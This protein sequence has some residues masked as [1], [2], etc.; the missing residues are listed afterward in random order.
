MKVESYPLNPGL[1]SPDIAMSVLLS[2]A[3]FPPS[4]RISCWPLTSLP[5][6]PWRVNVFGCVSV[7]SLFCPCERSL[8]IELSRLCELELVPFDADTAPP[9]TKSAIST[10]QTRAC[11]AKK[12]VMSSAASANSTNQRISKVKSPAYLNVQRENSTSRRTAR[13]LH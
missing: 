12:S 11:V 4:R 5:S 7:F 1:K 10:Q 8:L 2:S 6:L 3:S 9:A 13:H